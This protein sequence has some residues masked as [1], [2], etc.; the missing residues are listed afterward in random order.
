[1][2]SSTATNSILEVEGLTTTFA[3]DQGPFRAVEDISFSVSPR[4]VLALLGESG[5]GK[6]VTALSIMRLLGPAAAIEGSVRLAG[7][8]LVALPERE[9]REV[10]GERISI[11]FQNP[12]TALNPALRIG[13]QIAEAI[14]AHGNGGRAPKRRRSLLRGE[15]RRGDIWQQAIESLRRVGIPDPEVAAERWPHEF[16]GGMCQRA[17]I[18]AAIACSPQ[19]LIADEPTTALDVTVQREIIAL[20]DEIRTDANVAVLLVSHDFALVAEFADRA[21]VLYGGLVVERADAQQLLGAPRHPYT[22][23]LLE[24]VPALDED[25][26]VAAIPGSVPPRYDL[27][28]GCRFHERC[29]MA[30]D[31]CKQ[32]L[33]ALQQ[34]QEGHWVRCHQS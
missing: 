13:D 11:V 18:A 3:T 7:R 12:F 21:A 14:R 17:V 5:C 15:D 4:Q 25:H 10:R 9:M 1:M 19:V 8:E 16:S 22:R 31:R 27:I 32:E 26:V 30:D 24:C 6:T 33:P 23:A 20:L 29:E 34:A 2:A 28:P